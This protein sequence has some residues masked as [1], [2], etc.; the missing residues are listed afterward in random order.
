MKEL[1]LSQHGTFAPNTYINGS[2]PIDGIF[3]TQGIEAL[4]SGY[5]SF[6]WGMYSDHRLLWVDIDLDSLL[7]TSSIPILKPQARRLQSSNPTTV[8]A[9]NN[10]WRKHYK[11][12]VC[13][14]RK[15]G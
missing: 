15:K 11:K 5:E 12:R 8:N 7:G 6:T 14:R 3:A 2:T 1:I 9:F 13:K 10:L 4:F